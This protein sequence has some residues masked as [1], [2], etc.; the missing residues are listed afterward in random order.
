M[1][2]IENVEELKGRER[3]KEIRRIRE[4][5]KDEGEG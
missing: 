2:K 3:E 1:V 5:V 4:G